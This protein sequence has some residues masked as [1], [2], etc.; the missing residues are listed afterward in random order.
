[1]AGVA[2]GLGVASVIA[3]AALGFV[4]LSKRNDAQQACSQLCS[5]D[6]G[7]RK[8]DDAVQTG[9]FATGFFIAGGVVLAGAAVLWVTAPPPAPRTR[10]GVGLG[11]IHL[12]GAW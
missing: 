11:S 4:T 5:D 12:E 8:W 2:T 3:G 6:A 1:V 7:V 9:N 10:V